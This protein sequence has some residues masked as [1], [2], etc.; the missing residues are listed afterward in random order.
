MVLVINWALTLVEFVE[1]IL[2]RRVRLK[3]TWG[4]GRHRRHNT[5][6]KEG[7]EVTG[8]QLVTVLLATLKHSRQ[9][10]ASTLCA[11]RA[12]TTVSYHL[13]SYS[14]ICPSSLSVARSKRDSF[15]IM[16]TDLIRVVNKLQDT[17]AT[18]G[19]DLDMPQLVVVCL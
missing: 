13:L 4:R 16:D 5:L 10:S 6:T 15:P 3:L 12:F 7:C 11:S 17:F 8:H 18:L 19:G 9:N 1:N 2:G 14:L